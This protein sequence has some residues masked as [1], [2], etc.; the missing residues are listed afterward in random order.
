MRAGFRR[1]LAP[2]AICAAAR[3][4]DSP[5][6]QRSMDSD[7]ANIAAALFSDAAAAFV[8]CNEHAMTQDSNLLVL[9]HSMLITKNKGGRSI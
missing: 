3:N 8:L 7:Q 9:S 5:P 4:I 6:A 1:R 2:P